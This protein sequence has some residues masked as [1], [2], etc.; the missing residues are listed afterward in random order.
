MKK[1]IIV[2]A[3]SVFSCNY[4]EI[5]L[6][7]CDVKLGNVVFEKSINQGRQ[8][9]QID[10]TGKINMFSGTKTDYFN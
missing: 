5:E 8:N 3:A 9:T 2:M 6:K 10:S 4:T 7:D 1:W